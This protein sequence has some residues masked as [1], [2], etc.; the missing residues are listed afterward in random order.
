[1]LSSKEIWN[2][3][4]SQSQGERVEITRNIV[5]SALIEKVREQVVVNCLFF[6]PKTRTK[7]DLK[8]HI[9]K[10]MPKRLMFMLKICS[11]N[12]AGV[13]ECMHL[14]DLQKEM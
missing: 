14:K 3:I 12:Y 1:M 10:I 4:L 8:L 6:L 9:F 13:M 2:E 11:F 5:D 7:L